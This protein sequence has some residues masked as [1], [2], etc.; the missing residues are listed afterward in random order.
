MG[1]GDGDGGGE[2]EGRKKMFIK[3]LIAGTRSP[4]SK[5]YEL[6]TLVH[7]IMDDHLKEVCLYY[8]NVYVFLDIILILIIAPFIHYLDS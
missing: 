6:N 5:E 7:K 8:W 4:K 1:G 3:I 2:E